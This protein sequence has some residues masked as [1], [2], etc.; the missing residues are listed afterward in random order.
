MVTPEFEGWTVGDSHEFDDRYEVTEAEIVG[1]G[2][3][4]EPWV[5]HVDPDAADESEYVYQLTAGTLHVCA[6]GLR[7]LYDAVLADSRALDTVAVERS[8]REYQVHPGDSLGIRV[9]LVD[10]EALS[11]SRA[12]AT[13]EVA[14][15]EAADDLTV[16]SMRVVVA[17]KR[18]DGEAD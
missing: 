11:E 18:R 16:M 7:L 9:K 14:V 2:E 17:F 4:Y 5:H 10:T 13:L 12:T 8:W 15:F 1:F 6:M 3:R